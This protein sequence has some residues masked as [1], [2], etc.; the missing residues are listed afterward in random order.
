MKSTH[1]VG[2]SSESIELSF[3]AHRDGKDT[4]KTACTVK[5][6]GNSSMRSSESGYDAGFEKNTPSARKRSMEV[7]DEELE[8]RGIPRDV[9]FGSG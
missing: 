6:G 9:I 5:D 4:Y 7:I 8:K 3:V 2:N 1:T